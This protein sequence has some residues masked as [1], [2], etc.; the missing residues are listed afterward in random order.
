MK[1]LSNYKEK[2]A[3]ATTDGIL[4]SSY[5]WVDTSTDNVIPNCCDTCGDA[6]KTGT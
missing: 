3:T 5:C 4:D 2:T 1:G 6:N